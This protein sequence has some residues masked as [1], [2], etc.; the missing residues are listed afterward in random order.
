MP[1]LARKLLRLMPGGVPLSSRGFFRLRSDIFIPL[2][3]GPR[4]PSCAG[5]VTV[6]ES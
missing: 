2:C 4:E 1:A 3:D 6:G 5:P